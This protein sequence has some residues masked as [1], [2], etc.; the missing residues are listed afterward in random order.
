MNDSSAE[1]S[2]AKSNSAEA[3]SGESGRTESSRGNVRLLDAVLVVCA[4]LVVAYVASRVLWQPDE[5]GSA[6]GEPA[7]VLSVNTLV[8]RMQDSAEEVRSYTGVVRAGRSSDLS[9][10]RGGRV[11]KLLVSEGDDVQA[12]QPLAELDQ[13]RLELKKESLNAALSDATAELARL[14][15][16]MPE[17]TVPAMQ[18]KLRELRTELN[19]L[20]AELASQSRPDARPANNELLS[21]RLNSVEKQLAQLGGE[22]RRQKIESHRQRIAE[23]E[24]QLKDLD[25]ELESGRLIAP[26]DGVVALR[27][28][29]EGAVLSA[30]M[31]VLKLVEQSSLKVWVGIP[32]ELAARAQIGEQ[33]N[34]S[35]VEQVFGATIEAKL[36]QL[37]QTTRTRTIILKLAAAEDDQVLDG[38]VARVQ[39]RMKVATAGVWLPYTALSQEN[40]G[41]WS[42][43]VAEGEPQEQVVGQR[44]VELL[45]LEKDRA[46]VRGTLD[47]GELVIANGVHRV[48]PG[49]R[50]RSRNLSQLEAAPVSDTS[51]DAAS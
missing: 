20:D 33:V 22:S 30:G 24:G 13:R 9:F 47:E 23:L 2:S 34:L 37:D 15:P 44:Y 6:N 29:H 7:N 25:L 40:H 11:T 39:L 18:A 26:F 42:V 12:G 45:H 36:P 51:Q 4:V 28:V 17:L 46:F 41:L 16:E 43:F 35:I 14:A 31:P 32:I 19:Q 48:V 21:N 3:N 10:D 5:G 1:S 50:V 49:Q 27:N 38:Q 8:V